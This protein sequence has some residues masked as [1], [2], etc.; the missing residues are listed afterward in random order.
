MGTRRV[1][2]CARK[3]LTMQGDNEVLERPR[4]RAVGVG[5]QRERL[6]VYDPSQADGM[7]YECSL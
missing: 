1:V 2:R 7:G 4:R 6:P 3:H 5:A